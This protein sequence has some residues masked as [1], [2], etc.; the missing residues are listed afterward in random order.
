MGQQDKTDGCSESELESRYRYGE[1]WPYVGWEVPV[2]VRT[3][4]YD[5]GELQHL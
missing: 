5:L 4:V 3:V 1:L 2:M